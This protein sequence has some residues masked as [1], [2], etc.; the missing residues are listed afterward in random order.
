MSWH[1]LQDEGEDFSLA[2]YLDGIRS[3]QSKSEEM[4][5]TY[6]SNDSETEYL[7][8]SP[9]GTMSAPFMDYPGE[10]QLMLFPADSLARTSVAQE[11][12]QV[13]PESVAAFGKSISES[14]M[15]LDLILS[16]R[17]TVRASEPVDSAPSSRT[18][19]AWGMT[20]DGV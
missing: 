10:E 12:R 20:V 3:A 19:P 9:S 18:L 16:S 5:E 11:K 14:L 8:T 13:L 2:N 1:F 4:P 6:C 7:K 17:K 15:K